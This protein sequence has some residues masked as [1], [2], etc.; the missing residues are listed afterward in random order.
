MH[1]NIYNTQLCSVVFPIVIINNLADSI[2]CIISFIDQVLIPALG[3]IH[4]PSKYSRTVEEAQC[5]AAEFSLVQL[6]YPLEGIEIKPKLINLSVINCY[7]CFF[8]F[9]F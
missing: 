7:S 9:L 5:T 6:G 8:F 4:I 3:T 1:Y 2:H